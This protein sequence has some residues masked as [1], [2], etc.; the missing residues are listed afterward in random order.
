MDYDYTQIDHW[1]NGHAYASDGVLL[2]PTLHV[3]YNRILPDHILNAMAKG[4]CGVCGISN[5]RFEKT[6]PY[7]KMLS[8]Y[9]SGQL[10]LMYTIYWRSFGGLYPMM[11][12]KIEQDLNEINKIESEEIKESVKFTTDFYKEVFNTYGEKA[13]KLAKTIAEQSRG[14]RIRNVEDALRAYD[15]Y[16][17]NI[18]K[19]I[20]TKN[21]KIIASALESLNVDEIAKNLKKFSKGMGFVSYSIDANDLRIELVKAVE[22]D[23]WRP[24]FVKVE[25]I[26]IGIS[27]TGI[28][29][30]GFS[31]LLGG[32]VGI[33]GYGL[34]LAGI[35]SLI[36]DSLVEKA[37]KLVGL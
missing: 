17:T 26:L 36:D 4:L 11:K 35:G 29:G 18:N 21:R 20:D 8:A 5:C 37:N 3:S 14:K 33:L 34:I 24:F 1:K 16:K 27:A 31:F 12:P 25:T 30:L 7:K 28:T 32:P 19:K 13:E 6:S 10:E 15:K 22:T 2:L 23:N 9:Q